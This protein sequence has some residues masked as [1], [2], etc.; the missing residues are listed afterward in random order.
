M[1]AAVPVG[2]SVIVA[3]PVVVSAIAA[4]PA[5]AAAVQVVVQAR[6]NSVA[7]REVGAAPFKVSIAVA[8]RR[9]LQASAAARAG[10]AAV[11]AHEAVV[12]ADA[13]AE[14]AEGAADNRFQV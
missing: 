4:E 3:V 7:D 9:G 10:V 6:A 12:A 2:K 5:E 13:V 1:I 14:E 8:A 11:V